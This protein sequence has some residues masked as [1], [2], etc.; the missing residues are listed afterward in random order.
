MHAEPVEQ[1][2][3]SILSFF[4]METRVDFGLYQVP[5]KFTFPAQNWHQAAFIARMEEQVPEHTGSP[6]HKHDSTDKHMNCQRQVD[7]L[8]ASPV[9]TSNRAF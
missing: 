2:L 1:Q 3:T 6:S 4:Y 5:V 7:H 8:T 9:P